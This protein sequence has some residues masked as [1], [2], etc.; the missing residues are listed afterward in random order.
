MVSINIDELL[1]HR[2]RMQLVDEILE[3]DADRAVTLSTVTETWPFF[4]N[5]T[6]NPLVLIELAAQTA[7]ICFG[8][9]ELQ[10]GGKPA[11]GMGWLVGIKQA[12]F[13]RETLPM[14]S[15]I[16]TRFEKSFDFE[17]Y[18]EV[19]AEATIE[20]SLIGEVHLQIMQSD[21]G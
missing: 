3:M 20:G 11:E 10:K 12:S 2:D 19:M 18:H 15:R 17:N 16:I 14:G 9:K 8:W 6:V 7:G 21:S 13:Y 5:N 4:E 1:P